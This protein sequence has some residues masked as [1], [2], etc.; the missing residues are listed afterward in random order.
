[1]SGRFDKV[2]L[3]GNTTMRRMVAKANADRNVIIDEVIRFI[4]DHPEDTSRDQFVAIL[5]NLKR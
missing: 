4:L 1:M 5:R 3:G 2:D